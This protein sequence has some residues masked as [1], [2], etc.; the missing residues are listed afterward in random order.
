M[1]VFFL[2]EFL[3]D[4]CFFLDEFLI[5]EW[6]TPA[7]FQVEGSFSIGRVRRFELDPLPDLT[8][9][10]LD[11]LLERAFANSSQAPLLIGYGVKYDMDM[12]DMG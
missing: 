1:N 2:D 8:Q 6:L 9:A 7:F 5:D 3:I 12:A 4:E 10:E 11:V